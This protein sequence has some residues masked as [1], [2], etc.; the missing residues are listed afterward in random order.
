[1][2]QTKKP[3][4][5][6]TDHVDRDSITTSAV[7]DPHSTAFAERQR[8]P[9]RYENPTI[10]TPGILDDIDEEEDDGLGAGVVGRGRL[11]DPDDPA[12]SL[13]PGV[14]N[15]DQVQPMLDTLADAAEDDPA[16]ATYAINAHESDA[17]DVE[18]L[19]EEQK[20]KR[21]ENRQALAKSREQARAE[22]P[23]VASDKSTPKSPTTTSTSSTTTK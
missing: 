6:T 3:S 13:D 23:T 19:M 1:M 8:D 21:D 12:V 7:A 4:A 16:V 10:A 5:R 20:A 22:S 9:N 18:A 17:V 14:D 11:I 2:A 15:R